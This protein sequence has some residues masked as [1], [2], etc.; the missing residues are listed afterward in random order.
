MRKREGRGDAGVDVEA[1]ADARAVT[2]IL[3]ILNPAALADAAA[4]AAR[5]KSMT[6]LLPKSTRIRFHDPRLMMITRMMRKW[7]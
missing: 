6:N 4:V 1:A 5:M 2:P 3:V 7:K